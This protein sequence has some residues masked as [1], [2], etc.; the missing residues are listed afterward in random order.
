LFVL[1]DEEINAT[2]ELAEIVPTSSQGILVLLAYVTEVEQAGDSWPD[3]AEND[4]D[5]WGHSFNWFIHRNIAEL[6]RLM[7]AC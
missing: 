7:A 5:R 3:L 1:F 6:L 2:C 4:N